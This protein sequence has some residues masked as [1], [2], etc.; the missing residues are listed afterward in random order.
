MSTN[1]QNEKLTGEYVQKF[2]N[3]FLSESGASYR[4]Y[5]WESNLVARYHFNQMA[6]T[7]DPVLSQVRGTVLEVGGG[8]GVWTERYLPLVDRLV[9]L[10]ISESMISQAQKQLKSSRVEF[11]RADFLNNQLPSSSFD[12]IVSIRNFEYFPDKERA[13]LEFN[14]LV[15]PG[16]K[17]ILVTKNPR[18]DW[19]KYFRAKTLH[20]GQLS[21]K[22][23][24]ELASQNS[25]EIEL[26]KPTIFGKKI[27]WP[28]VGQLFDLLH[29]FIVSM[30]FNFIPLA[31]M[32]FFSESFLIM[33]KRTN[34]R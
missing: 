23:I 30:G 6:R 17:I 12:S 8:D 33:L 2:Y 24:S 28:I 20:S 5:R 27:S 15:R 1:K 11:V 31:L 21:L 4:W 25:L 18:A 14:R 3:R 9:F 10:D 16:G 29:R 19:R 22:Q 26:I 32:E 34:D 7:L 13:M